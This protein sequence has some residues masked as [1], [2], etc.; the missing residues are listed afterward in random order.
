MRGRN[1]VEAER[2]WY[3]IWFRHGSFEMKIL[4]E[5]WPEGKDV[6]WRSGGGDC[7]VSRVE[8]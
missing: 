5:R 2:G 7:Y 1:T 8:E 6:V 4:E 3:I